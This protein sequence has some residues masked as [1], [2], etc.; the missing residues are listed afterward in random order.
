MI[1]A[2]WFIHEYTVSYMEQYD[3]N[4][5]NIFA[6]VV[7]NRSFTVAARKLGIPKSTVSRAVSALEERLAGQLLYRTTREVTATE[8]GQKLFDH[9]AASMTSLLAGL[10]V[11][12]RENISM[13]M[14]G[15]IRITSVEDIGN[16]I[17]TPVLARFSEKYPDLKFDMI[18]SL[19]VIDLV[20]DAVD[21]AVRIGPVKQQTYR[22][23][24]VGYVTF[25]L[26]ASPRYLERQAI[27]RVNV[28]RPESLESMDIL[29]LTEKPV[30]P[31]RVELRNG[32]QHIRLKLQAKHLSN[33]TEALLTLAKNGRGVALIPDFMAR[34]A[35]LD[36]SLVEVC[37][38]WHLAPMPVSIVTPAKRK[39]SPVVEAFS[40][41]LYESL[42]QSFIKV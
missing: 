25:V 30:D 22:A 8:L 4:H 38:G 41:F 3:L 17:V 26:A 23:R 1:V 28:Q 39:L 24:K 36:G 19:K 18:Y 14:N 31:A 15:T 7:E 20:K 16:H 42:R 13:T 37:R 33:S 29:M 40:G 27:G 9:V 12:Q 11:V 6:A 5:L 35:F 10:D 32:Q 21:I 2:P 34:P